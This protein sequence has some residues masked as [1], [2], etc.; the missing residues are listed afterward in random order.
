MAAIYVT[1]GEQSSEPDLEIR[2]QANGAEVRRRGGAAWLR[3]CCGA[4]GAMHISGGLPRHLHS[5]AG[6]DTAADP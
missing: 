3:R 6:S 2:R 1:I 5:N 4:P